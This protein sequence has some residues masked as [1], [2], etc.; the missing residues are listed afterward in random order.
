VGG[1]LGV[2][3]GQLAAGAGGGQPRHP[4]GQLELV[5]ELVGVDALGGGDGSMRCIV[6]RSPPSPS[7]SST[8]P[9]A[10][11]LSTVLVGP[12][13]LPAR[14]R[15]A[16]RGVRRP[17]SSSSPPSP[18]DPSAA[19][20]RHP[21]PGRSV[22]QWLQAPSQERRRHPRDPLAP[23]VVEAI[24]R[25]LPPEPDAD[26]LVFTAPGG[27]NG[28]PVGTR[29]TLSR[30]GFR[31]PFQTATRRAKPTSRTCSSGD[32]TIFGTASRPGWRRRASRRT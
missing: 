14:H 3:G 18:S 32:P 10:C 16:V 27:G 23:L 6:A 15:A 11:S 9:A 17:A 29:T 5:G 20:R 31:R 12:H 13:A 30:H 25:Q 7:N 28:V 24:R 22:R 2:D 1:Q 26:A 4:E 21:L 19:G 8:G